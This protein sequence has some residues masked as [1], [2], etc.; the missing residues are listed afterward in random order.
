MVLNLG[1]HQ[2]DRSAPWLF[3]STSPSSDSGGNQAEL[4]ESSS[5][6][7][8]MTSCRRCTW[9]RRAGQSR[10]KLRSCWPRAPESKLFHTNLKGSPYNLHLFSRL[11]HPCA[12]K[13]FCF[14]KSQWK[15]QAESAEHPLQAAAVF[16][17][18]AWNLF[19]LV[20]VWTCLYIII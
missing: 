1:Q 15:Y 13:M 2:W 7:G 14:V 19:V 20:L 5:T 12:Y 17:V 3:T 6:F 8:H 9:H 11:L 16:A 10:W 4:E 18:P